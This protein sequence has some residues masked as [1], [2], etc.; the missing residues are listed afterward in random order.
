VIATALMAAAQ[1]YPADSPVAEQLKRA[2]AAADAIAAIPDAQRTFDNSVGA[3]DDLLAHLDTHTNMLRFMQY[4]ST[5]AAEREASQKAEEHV[6]NWL[7]EF[8]KREDVYRAVRAVAATNSKLEGERK[9]LLERLLRDYRRA[10]M[11]LPPDKREQLKTV[12][13]EIARLG[14]EFE[15]NIRDDQTKVLVSG[16]GLKGMPDDYINGL[17]RE[18][19]LYVITMD[20]PTFNPLMDFCEVEQTRM[21]AWKAYKRRA[22]DKNVAL[23]EQILK[24]RAQAAQLLGYACPADFE[25]EVRMAKTSAAVRDFYAKLRPLVRTKAAADLAEFTAAKRE[26]TGRPDARLEPWDQSCYEKRL[27]KTHYAVDAQK[28]REYFSMDRV[29]DGLFSITQS[30]YGL[31]YR[32]VTDAAASRGRPLWHPDVR[33][34]EVWDKADGRMLGEFYIDLYPRENKYNHAAQWGLVSRKKWPDGSLQRPLAALVC[35]FT[36]PTADKPSLLSHLEVETFFHEFGHCL[37][38][39]LTEADYGMFAGTSVARDFVEAPSQMFE[40]WVWDA[41]VLKS[42]ARHY[43]TGEPFPD[44]T[45]DGMIRARYLGSGLKAE[46]Q[47]YYGI[48]DLTYH[49]RPDGIVDTTK[50]AN[51]LFGDVE[52]FP[53]QNDTCYQASFGHLIGYQAGYY[54]YQWSLVYA[55]DMFQRFRELGVLSPDA[56]QYYR[57]KILARGSTIDELDIVKDY[58]GREPRMEAYL[59]R[60]GLKTE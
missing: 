6:Q 40:N 44:E 2:V 45:L 56:G 18:G 35:N 50:V 3:V 9:R 22:G 15:K 52:Q 27:L 30:L 57:K 25:I 36:K 55:C 48:V 43:K 12:E 20:Y 19:D 59:E 53:P 58:L 16:D 23:L 60:L 38:T 11:E 24:L 13:K 8:N 46:R 51:A 17:K 54:G 33:L 26:H 29:V 4:V 47:F 39:I 42:F 28:V 49:S 14:I 31:E 21:D 37:H 34:F 32:D 1:E 10:G 7:I 5:D 41:R